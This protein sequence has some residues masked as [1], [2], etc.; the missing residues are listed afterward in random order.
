MWQTSRNIGQ[1]NAV[2]VHKFGGSSLADAACY[3][4]VIEILK[5]QT[6]PGDMVV[7][8]AAGKT[9]NA[10]VLICRNSGEG[11]QEALE[12]TIGDLVR[13]QS[14]LIDEGSRNQLPAPASVRPCTPTLPSCA[15]CCRSATASAV[16]TPWSALASCGQRG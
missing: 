6:E 7:V 11:N 9:T 1:A 4:R 8:S 10:L 16:T 12:Q 13:F 5:S 15:A 2:R 14:R 3:H